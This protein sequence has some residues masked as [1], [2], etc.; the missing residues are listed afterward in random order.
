MGSL[1]DSN[2]KNDGLGVNW[3]IEG[4]ELN[5]LG[6]HFKRWIGSEKR[7]REKY[8]RTHT[9]EHTHTYIHTYT[10]TLP[11]KFLT[12]GSTNQIRSKPSS[13][14]EITE[15]VSKGRIES[16]WIFGLYGFTSFQRALLT[17]M[18]GDATGMKDMVSE[19]QG[20]RKGG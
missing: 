8:A 7:Y 14:P 5:C 19:D 15:K 9:H 13:R 6:N 16:I 18:E 11:T 12:F 10:H 4:S 17:G 1:I 2:C 3:R 20:V